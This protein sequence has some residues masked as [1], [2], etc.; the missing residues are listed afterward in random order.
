MFKT[1]KIPYIELLPI[2]L[3]TILCYK[4]IGNFP[5]LSKSLSSFLS[6]LGSIFW[7]F[8]IAYFLN[9]LLKFIEHNFKTKRP[10]TLLIIYMLLFGLI[11]LLFTII[12]P[13]I[14]RSLYDL[15]GSMPTYINQTTYWFEDF[16]EQLS[17]SSFVNDPDLAKIINPAFERF[18][19]GLKTIDIQSI[20]IGIFSTLSKAIN[21]TSSF[22]KAIFGVIVSIYLLK[23]KESFIS[24]T[25]KIIYSLFN[26][27]HAESIIAF[28]SHANIVFNKFI[29]GKALDSLIIGVLCFLGLYLLKIPYASLISLIVGITNMIPYFG[30]FIGAIPAIL[31]TLITSTSLTSAIFVAILILILQQFDGWILGPKILGDSVGVG[32]FAIIVAI[33]IGGKLFGV[34]GMFLSVPV[35]A[36]LIDA[37]QKFTHK[38]MKDKNI[39]L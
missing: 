23:D 6:Y 10:I 15:I 38:R 13:R 16:M 39:E 30:P 2:I 31:I 35:V 14:L 24:N 18:V 22:V 27:N 36:L 25:K 7:A 17:N 12:T 21:F 1:R 32:P 28:G 4:L 9:P 5:T 37:M 26:K 8:G 20:F 3:L 29:L 34:L 11:F 19:Q 33:L